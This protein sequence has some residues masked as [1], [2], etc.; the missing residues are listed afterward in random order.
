[1]PALAC[2]SEPEG[3]AC[4][5]LVAAAAHTDVLA[6]AQESCSKSAGRKKQPAQRAR[7]FDGY[8]AAARRI[9]Y[10]T[11]LTPLSSVER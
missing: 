11:P 3:L 9:A 5:R 4:W 10:R 8:S 2:S 7:L 6:S 1:M